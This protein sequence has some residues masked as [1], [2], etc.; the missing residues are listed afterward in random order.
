MRL[1]FLAHKRNRWSSRLTNAAGSNSVQMQRWGNP[2]G[3]TFG[4]VDFGG[5]IEAEATF[6]R[7]TI[8][9]RV[10]VGWFF[11]SPRF[12]AEGEFFR[13]TIDDVTFQ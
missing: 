9:T 2:G 5:V 4:L 11:G 3:G 12:E 6:G 8:P 13:V 10:R 7:Y 1:A